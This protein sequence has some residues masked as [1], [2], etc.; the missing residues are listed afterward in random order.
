MI[1]PDVPAEEWA[2]RY[3]LDREPYPCLRCGVPQ[4]LTIPY[5]HG[6]WRGLLSSH[7]ECGEKYRQ[8]CATSIDPRVVAPFKELLSITAKIGDPCPK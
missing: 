8:S 4:E 2:R 1:Y 5:A 3:G 6:S 7:L